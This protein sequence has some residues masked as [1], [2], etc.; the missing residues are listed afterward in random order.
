[1]LP[2]MAYVHAWYPLLKN[3]IYYKF[4]CIK[5]I[6]YDWARAHLN[7]FDILAV[8]VAIAISLNVHT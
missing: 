2:K 7:M 1:M 3:C 8:Y 5:L 4:L 6:F